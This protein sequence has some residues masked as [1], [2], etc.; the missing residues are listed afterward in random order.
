MVNVFALDIF[1]VSKRVGL[2]NRRYGIRHRRHSVRFYEVLL[3][4]P[5]LSGSP[6]QGPG[7]LLTV[8]C[9]QDISPALAETEGRLPSPDP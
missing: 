6:E 5:C 3:Y 9:R 4:S 7:G 1:E 2:I 8:C